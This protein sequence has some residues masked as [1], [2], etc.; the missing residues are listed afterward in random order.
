MKNI[1]LKS[2]VTIIALYAYG[3]NAQNT[4]IG[5]PSGSYKD[6]ATTYRDDPAKHAHTQTIVIDKD[7]KD[8]KATSDN[9]ENAE[10]NNSGNAT[11]NTS[12][13]SAE[14]GYNASSSTTE[15]SA[16]TTTEETCSCNSL[17]IAYGI[18]AAG[19][20]GTLIFLALYLNEK[21]KGKDNS[22]S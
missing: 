22:R 1:T 10:T 18:S 12:T 2:L 21:N 6:T 16:V 4:S 8:V 14:Q 13:P 17:H 3:L 20:L 9:V 7:K 15:T 19:I 5:I 11:D